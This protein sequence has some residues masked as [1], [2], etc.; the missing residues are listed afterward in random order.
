MNFIKGVFSFLFSELSLCQK[1]KQE[2]EKL[3]PV[4]HFVP[5]CKSDGSFKKKQC[6][7]STGQCWCV[8][9]NGQEWSGTRTRGDLNCT[10]SGR[11]RCSQ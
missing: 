5:Q 9:H 10:T 4:G 7:P 3:P 6:H 2:A 11:H 1:K 8:D